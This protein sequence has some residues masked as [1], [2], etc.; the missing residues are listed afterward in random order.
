ML[1]AGMLGYPGPI[2][3]RYTAQYAEQLDRTRAWRSRFRCV[4]LRPCCVH[5]V[6][7][8]YNL[9]AKASEDVT[10]RLQALGRNAV[11]GDV[12]GVQ[13]NLAEVCAPAIL[14]ISGGR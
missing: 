2:Q 14:F 3:T 5:H 13:G 8:A 6:T 1:P 7:H 10:K 9:N 4:G 12:P 11:S